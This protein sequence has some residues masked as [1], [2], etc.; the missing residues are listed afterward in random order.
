MNLIVNESDLIKRLQQKNSSIYNN[1]TF[2]DRD[3]F[4]NIFKLVFECKNKKTIDIILKNWDNLIK[5][6]ISWGKKTKMIDNEEE[7]LINKIH[8]KELIMIIN[9]GK[10]LQKKKIK[11]EVAFI[12]SL[13]LVSAHFVFEDT[14]MGLCLKDIYETLPE[15][16]Q[17]KK[18]KQKFI[19]DFFKEGT[20]KEI[21]NIL[22]KI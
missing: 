2:Y 12:L 15:N 16:L 7:Q 13:G 22:F 9:I 20:S 8:P 21:R 11:P 6:E 5:E 14:S 3:K 4:K 10:I 1:K 17:S 19:F 18:G